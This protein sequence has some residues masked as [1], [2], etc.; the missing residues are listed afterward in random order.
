[1]NA[2]PILSICIPIYNRVSCL[3][4]SLQCFLSEKELFLNDI[5]LYISDNCSE[6]DIE[7]CIRKY[8]QQ[9]LNVRYHRNTSNLGMDGNFINCFKQ[10]RGKYIW[11]LGSDDVMIEGKCLQRIIPIL[12]KHELGVLYLQN[13]YNPMQS[14]EL[15]K[16]KDS[17]LVKISYWITFI[18]VN[19]VKS[20]YVKE[21]NFE[22]YRGTLISQI[23]LYLTAITNEKENAIL[24]EKILDTAKDGSTNGGFNFIEV[25]TANFLNILL[26][27]T[28]R[29]LIEENTYKYIKK[30]I[31]YNHILSFIARFYVKR[32]MDKYSVKDGWKILFHWYGMESYFYIAILT[33]PFIKIHNYLVSVLFSRLINAD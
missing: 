18:S 15:S 25:F 33:Y 14:L 13:Q 3:E 27:F 19:I 28:Q 12:E 23:P 24:Y 1:M 22:K 7:G 30:K 5:E 32:N 26:D 16:C 4:L 20:S 31:F 11:L 10:A 8:Q 21:I 6:D 17:F 29:K 2:H 9:G